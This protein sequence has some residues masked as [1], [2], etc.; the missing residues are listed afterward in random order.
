M[1]W[2]WGGAKNGGCGQYFDMTTNATYGAWTN[3]WAR[4]VMVEDANSIQKTA[5][6][7]ASIGGAGRVLFSVDLTPAN[8]ATAVTGSDITLTAT[9]FSGSNV[10]TKVEF[11]QGSAK[12]GEATTAPFT[13]L[14]RNVPTGVHQ[15]TAKG[16]D[17]T[18][19][20]GA[21]LVP[22]TVSVFPVSNFS[23][24]FKFVSKGSG[25]V[26]D[27]P[28]GT[29]TNLTQVVQNPDNG[30]ASAQWN[31]SQ[32]GGGLY[33]ITNQAGGTCLDLLGGSTANGAQIQIY[34]CAPVDQQK[35]NI[36]QVDANYYII[37]SKASG[38]CVEVSRLTSTD[39]VKI[40]QSDYAGLDNQKWSVQGVA[41]LA[42][43]TQ[44]TTPALSAWLHPNPAL[45]QVTVE[46][47]ADAAQP[48]SVTMTDLM[49]RTLRQINQAAG[50]GLNRL[51]LFLPQQLPSGVYLLRVQ[52]D[53]QL[54]TQRFLVEK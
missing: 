11:F 10:I 33:K 36:T 40:D 38:K 3:E 23:G 41:A 37:T 13:Y 47:W 35:W 29:S 14:W 16:T 43:A 27:N 18:G 25:K 34:D 31:V 28:G 54:E 53:G 15:L 5:I 49:G 46:Y 45:Q 8:Y 50:K 39:G 19:G 6:R 4:A 52:H 30:S 48:V 9:A 24:R 51:T 21:T 44:G 2:S 32:L 1:P 12:L 7:P 42:V 20:T 26:L 17:A 22:T